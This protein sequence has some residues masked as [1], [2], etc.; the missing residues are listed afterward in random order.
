MYTFNGL[1]KTVVRYAAGQ[2]SPPRGLAADSSGSQ[3]D[4]NGDEQRKGGT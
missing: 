3:P 2:L 4:R 1:C